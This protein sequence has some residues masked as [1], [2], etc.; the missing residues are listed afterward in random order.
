M[1]KSSSEHRVEMENFKKFM[2]ELTLRF[3][4][5]IND[6][7][8][9]SWQLLSDGNRTKY[10]F[11]I[12]ERT[13][14]NRYIADPSTFE[15]DTAK[16]F[17]DKQQHDSMQLTSH[18][19][20]IFADNRVLLYSNTCTAEPSIDFFI[21]SSRIYYFLCR[22]QFPAIFGFNMPSAGASLPQHVHLQILPLVKNPHLAKLVDN[23][24]HQ[25]SIVI[26]EDLGI[27]LSLNQFPIL[28]FNLAFDKTHQSATEIGKKLF[29]AIQKNI[30]IRS[31]LHYT[32]NII[33]QTQKPGV[34][35]IAVRESYKQQPFNTMAVQQLLR[36]QFPKV[37][38]R[39]LI[40]PMLVWKFGWLEII[41]GLYHR[42]SILQDTNTFNYQFWKKISNAISVTPENF[43]RIIAQVL[44]TLTATTTAAF[45]QDPNHLTQEQKSVDTMQGQLLNEHHYK[46]SIPQLRTTIYQQ[47]LNTSDYSDFPSQLKQILIKQKISLPKI[48]DA[49]QDNTLITKDQTLGNSGSI[50]F[51]RFNPYDN[52][53]SLQLAMPMIS[54]KILLA[55]VASSEIANSELIV[56]II[57]TTTVLSQQIKLLVTFIR[58]N[59]DFIYTAR[60]LTILVDLIQ[61]LH[62]PSLDQKHTMMEM[63]Q[64]YYNHQQYLSIIESFANNPKQSIAYRKITLTAIQSYKQ[65]IIANAITHLVNTNTISM[66]TTKRKAYVQVTAPVRVELSCCAASDLIPISYERGG[67]S[68]NFSV[69]LNNKN[70]LQVTCKT[71]Y[72]NV[73]NI[74]AIDL[75]LYYSIRTIEDFHKMH[76]KLKLIKTAL[77][78]VGIIDENTKKTLPEILYEIG[79]GIEITTSSDVPMGSGLGISSILGACVIKA[80]YELMDIHI[81]KETLVKQVLLLEDRMQ[82][83]GG[84][85][86]P[87]GGIYPGLK[88]TYSPKFTLNPQ[89]SII[90]FDA[91]I[92]DLLQ[93]HIVLFY[94]ERVEQASTNL[95]YF[96]D[97][98]LTRF[99]K[100]VM[101]YQ[102]CVA[103]DNAIEKEIRS[104]APNIAIL[105]KL[106]DQYREAFVAFYPN[107]SNHIIDE[108]FT[109]VSPLIEGGKLSGAGSGG[110]ITFIAKTNQ[111]ANL[112]EKLQTLA[113]TIKYQHHL[114]AQCATITIDKEGIVAVSSNHIPKLSTNRHP[115]FSQATYYKKLAIVSLPIIA[116]GAW[117][118][119]RYLGSRSK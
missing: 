70:P 75:D 7:L 119:S 108:I 109:T 49:R 60:A 100:F 45:I 18:V 78:V 64:K 66:A 95:N 21:D 72:D 38:E 91:P 4:E 36:H 88:S 40:D 74:H 6:S 56:D 84:W 29:Y 15:P 77:M 83:S 46:C 99:P 8:K 118:S 41:G 13:D 101:A 50:I 28:G 69:K 2:T 103:I 20:A 61:G 73:I 34:F 82:A 85:Q 116:A 113:K 10:H 105:G 86:D 90:P 52:E 110:F 26:N 25:S 81:S 89:V 62:F 63:Y 112:I 44:H 12:K 51:S 114:T 3:K 80:L 92:Y 27:S 33:A 97:S 68:I 22:Q 31:Q 9:N 30:R 67:K 35:S 76:K 19:S 94:I 102:Q 117:C 87:V 37:A 43:Q 53:Q 11:M 5:P 16:C 96:I 58:N 24:K 107:F 111:K 47:L 98:H 115:L 48:V 55:I 17:C 106:L 23:I 65:Q 32:Y 39:I 42:N 104:N 57:T 14:V 59:Y 79:G 54:N 71:L 93:Q 1:T